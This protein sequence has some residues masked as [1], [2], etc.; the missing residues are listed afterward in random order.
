MKNLKIKNLKTKKNQNFWEFWSKGLATLIASVK[1]QRS[2]PVG[3]LPDTRKCSKSHLIMGATRYSCHISTRPVNW[4]TFITNLEANTNLLSRNQNI[5]WLLKM[6]YHLFTAVA[7]QLSG[8]QP[9]H[10]LAPKDTRKNYKVLE[11]ICWPN[12]SIFYETHR[13]SKLLL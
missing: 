8:T 2:C 13:H 3:I 1:L 9:P 12:P 6:V 10:F 7:Q 4:R 11:N 5:C